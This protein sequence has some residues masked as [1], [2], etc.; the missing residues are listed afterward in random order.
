M[1]N[2]LYISTTEAGSGKALVALGLGHQLLRRTAGVRF[3]RP[4]IQTTPDED[5]DLITRHFAL[6]Q[7]VEASFGL[8][9]G[10]MND[11]I[12]ANRINE[13]L[14]RIISRYQALAAANRFM[15]CESSD[16]LGEGS[17]FEFNLNQEIARNL[18]C[19]ILILGNAHQR[20]GD[21]ALRPVRLAV[22]TY[23]RHG[24]RIVGIVLNKADPA[25]ADALR[26]ALEK[27]FGGRDWVLS[28]IPYDRRLSSPRL[29]DIAQHLQAEVLYGHEGLERLA[30]HQIVA[31]MQMQHALE[32]LQE[33]SL[34]ITPGDRGDVIMGMLQAHQSHN[35]PNL[36]G[37]LLTG[38]APEPAIDRLIQGLPNPLPILAVASDTFTTVS[39]LRDIHISLKGDDREKIA[40]SI[41]AFERHGQV[42]RL[43]RTVNLAPPPEPTPRMFHHTI[44]L[45]ASRRPQRI[46][47]PEAL[48]PRILRAAAQVQA[49]GLAAP[50]LLGEPEEIERVLRQEGIDL[51]L[52]TVSVVSP[53]TSRHLERYI[54][55]FVELRR[56][57][58]GTAAIARDH[59][60]DA[61]TFATMMVLSGDADGMVSGATHT[62][63][64][65]IRPA[66]QL[67]RSRPGVSLISSVFVM[68]LED[69]VVI[70]GD[71]AVNPRPDAAQLAQIAISS[72]ETARALGLEPR[73]AMLS[74]SS[75]AS[76]KGEEVEKVRQATA[77]V[78]ERWPELPIEGPIQYDAAVSP[79]VALQKLPGSA[80]GGRATVL[81]FPDLN[82]GNN[83]YKAVQRETGAIAIGPIL[84]GL[85]KPVNDLS[86]GCSLEDIVST[87]AIT[88]IQAQLL[89]GAEPR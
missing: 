31:A 77:Q 68:L 18:G 66:L 20:H 54:Q 80:V 43:L 81:V 45:R 69:R 36:S 6:P 72:A 65:T 88:A 35:Y 85:N 67:I 4:V 40:L 57:K 60:L 62:T 1:S 29:L 34:V 48:V 15:L 7:S 75:G 73:V 21:E 37:L 42:E 76:G 27:D 56:H 9:T 38:M 10:E 24:C 86:R 44:S 53:H 8:T 50:I 55:T 47:L 5:I 41:E 79:E 84:Q 83:T 30:L 64:H 32:W 33:G 26:D 82:T 19:P 78:R 46:V 2:A 52:E 12:A 89:S 11:L 49:Q 71:C 13:G 87:I 17:A 63:Q 28:V 23:R 39:R 14:E 51:D 25:G 58:G 16:Y 59:L 74:Y 61:T 70:Y 3:F 22:E